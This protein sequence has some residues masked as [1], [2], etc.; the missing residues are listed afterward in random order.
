MVEYDLYRKEII[1]FLQTVTIKFELFSE[2]MLTRL[3]SEIGIVPEHPEDNP[4]YKNLCGE[5][6]ELDTPM[7]ITSVDTGEEVLFDKHL[8]TNHPK[9]AAIY[10]I[11]SQEFEILCQKYP[12]QVGLIKSI[13]YPVTDI[14]TAISAENFSLLAYDSSILHSNERESL[15]LCLER[16]LQYIYE[17]WYI[18]DYSYEKLYPIT[19]M[20]I[21]WAILPQA[22]LAQRV[23]NI[24]TPYVHPL[25]IWEYLSAKGLKSYRDILTDTQALY[26]YRNIDYIL[27]NKG[28]KRTLEILAENLLKDLQVKLVGKTILQQ[29]LTRNDE[30]ITVPEFLSEGVVNYDSAE[31]LD[32]ANFE[33]MEQIIRRIEQEGYFPDVT[34][35]GIDELTTRFG[36]TELN[37]VPT[38]LLELEKAILNTTYAGL[39]TRFL[40]ESMVY[41][42]SKGRLQYRIQF[43]D[44]NTNTPLDLTVEQTLALFQYVHYKQFGETPTVLPIKC[45]ICCVYKDHKPTEQDIDTYLNFEDTKYLLKSIVDINKVTSDV[46]YTTGPF[47]TKEEF[48]YAMAY[49][50]EVLVNHIEDLRQSGH[51][52]FHRGMKA[53]YK[54]LLHNTTIEF[55]LVQ[56]TTYE[57]WISSVPQIANL[58]AAYEDLPNKKIF[59]SELRDLL[60]TQLVPK[61]HEIFTRYTAYNKDSSILYK[62]LMDLFVQLCSYRLTFLETDRTILTFITSPHV[63]CA[64]V[65][66]EDVAFNNLGDI[67]LRIT[68][69]FTEEDTLDLTT[70]DGLNVLDSHREDFDLSVMSP[71]FTVLDDTIEY[72][73]T[74]QLTK[75]PTIVESDD[76]SESVITPIVIGST[77]YRFTEPFSEE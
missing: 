28:K 32:E 26:L 71:G 25:H 7:Y 6:S 57:E 23:R 13:V 24:K 73:Q 19:F 61:E 27:Q 12:E 11:P 14:Q 56:E 58:L 63:T 69:K 66:G 33:S 8:K 9:T 55:S 53:L 74:N 45:P 36:E 17:R 5:Y 31:E 54:S 51:L 64:T 3:E 35:E 18:A 29:T 38:R 44:P 2:M 60:F 49:Q 40:F 42:Y 52:L 47:E 68:T 77:T 75:F 62:R 1:N 65:G 50:F 72:H 59:Y 46:P 37:I 15:V 48:I 21:I 30:C 43:T 67:D 20:G 70:F 76:K 34:V 22:L 10:K 41:N 16:T 4:Y 39:L